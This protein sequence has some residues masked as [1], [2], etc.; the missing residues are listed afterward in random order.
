MKSM[1]RK[2]VIGDEWL[3]YKIYCGPKTADIV[4]IN[5]IRHVAEKLFEE[6]IIDKWFFIRYSDPKLHLRVRFCYN[7]P[8]NVSTIIN[9]MNSL[10]KPY[11]EQDLIN[12]IQIDTYK[13][14]LER[15]GK[16][17]IELAEELFYHDSKM[18]VD[19]VDLIEGDEGEE[20]RWLFGLRAIDNLLDDF[21]YNINQKLEL[22]ENL[23]EGFGK[24]FGMNK[25]LKLQLDKKY[26]DSRSLINDF[27]QDKYREES[28]ESL[29]ELLNK[30]SVNS[31]SIYV[32]I[33]KK[34]SENLLDVTL[35]N[36]MGSYIHMLMN[37]LFMSKQRL[38]E[39]AVYDFLYRY[40]KSEMAKKKIHSRPKTDL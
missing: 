3:Y 12:N 34:E 30:K 6:N 24:E 15:Y 22:L 13:R 5:V 21:S 28:I 38:N 25:S 9:T 8:E 20:I 11:I 17:T 7:N 27:F 10:T 29:T 2:F 1:Q 31:K 35:N 18:I 36:L 4:L 19:F 37:R 33:L 23:K 32:E 16:K 26:R 39:M 14:E 40:Y